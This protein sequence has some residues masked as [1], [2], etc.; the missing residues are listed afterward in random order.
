LTFQHL[1]AMPGVAYEAL[2]EIAEEQYGYLTTAQANDSGVS[3]QAVHQMVRRGDLER[4]SWGVYRLGHFPRSPYDQYVEATLWPLSVRGVVSHE[5]A[6]ALYGLSDV[7]PAKLHVTVPRSFR[8]QRE[9]PKVLVIHRADLTDAEIAYHEG[10]PVTTP[11]RAIRDCHATH[12]GPALVRQAIEDG[13]RTGLLRR[14]QA[15]SLM[16][17]LLGE[18]MTAETE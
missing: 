18:A 3:K 1:P 13:R 7:N 11:E 6:L 12:L 8:V 10:I 9:V 15:E 4:V 5:S 16:A 14:S 17:E 2:Y